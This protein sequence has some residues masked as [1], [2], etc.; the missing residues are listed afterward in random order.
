MDIL[1]KLGHSMSSKTE[2]KVKLLG[3]TERRP[4]SKMTSKY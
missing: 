3:K 1:Q 4:F 2:Y